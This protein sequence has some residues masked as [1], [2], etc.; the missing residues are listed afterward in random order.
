MSLH[1]TIISVLYLHFFRMQE[2]GRNV[3]PWFQTVVVLSFFLTILLTLIVYL[4]LQITHHGYYQVTVG[5]GFFIS[6]FLS[7]LIAFF[8][9]IKSFFFNNGKHLQYLDHF[10]MLPKKTQRRYS[11]MVLALVTVS[12]FL[13]VLIIYLFDNR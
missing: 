3:I 9:L 4:I 13:L 5:E 11:V 1:S 12:P 7:L 2:K 6:G 8:I 10:K